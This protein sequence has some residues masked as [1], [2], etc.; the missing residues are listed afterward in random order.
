VLIGHAGRI[1]RSI[2]LDRCT[3]ELRGSN[4]IWNN[5]ELHETRRV[6]LDAIKTDHALQAIE[7]M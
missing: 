3:S 6:Q 5:P 4:D 2:G 7:T 1:G